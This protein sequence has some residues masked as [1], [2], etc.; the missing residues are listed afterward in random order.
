MPRVSEANA[1]RFSCEVEVYSSRSWHS[2]Q[3]HTFTSHTSAQCQLEPK[4]LL[5]LPQ[6]GPAT[7]PVTTS[8]WQRH[9]LLQQLID[10]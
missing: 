2:A 10:L 8:R 6:L 9:Q 3:M 7:C 1:A 4:K 5:Q